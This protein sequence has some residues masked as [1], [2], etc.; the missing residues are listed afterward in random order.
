MSR[1]TGMASS[2]FFRQTFSSTSTDTVLSLLHV[3]VSLSV[4]PVPAAL[5][6]CV[7]SRPKSTVLIL[8]I[9]MCLTVYQVSSLVEDAGQLAFELIGF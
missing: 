7:R 2:R 3:H 9:H 8:Y 5:P 6:G 1:A 4:L